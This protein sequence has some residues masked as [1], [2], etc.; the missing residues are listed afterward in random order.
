MTISAPDVMDDAY[1][2]ERDLP[3][4][5][6]IECADSVRV[7]RRRIVSASERDRPTLILGAGTHLRPSAVAADAFDV[8]VTTGCDQILSVDRTNGTVTAEAGVRWGQLGARLRD[9]DVSFARPGLHRRGATLGGLLSNPASVALAP[10]VVGLTACTAD[11]RDYRYVEAPRKAAGPDL[12]HLFIGCEGALG[13]IL[14][15]TLALRPRP[16]ARLWRIS[17]EPP[18]GLLHELADLDIRVAWSWNDPD[19]ASLEL[20]VHGPSD[21]LEAWGTAAREHLPADVD[22]HVEDAEAC[23][24]RRGEIE[25]EMATT[26]T[27]FEQR[28]EDRA[29]WPGWVGP[30]KRSLDGAGALVTGPGGKT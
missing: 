17:G 22:L 19:E 21:L 1:W 12:R 23:R 5:G 6:D 18:P 8:V 13:A 27:D 30:I 15:V 20:A 7:L 24:R 2:R 28:G 14:T 26:Q 29:D 16:D 25:A 4:P 10:H 9:D 3:T 11:G